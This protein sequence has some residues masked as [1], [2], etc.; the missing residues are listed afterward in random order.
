MC[1]GELGVDSYASWQVESYF[2][3]RSMLLDRI[4]PPI[5]RHIEHTHLNQGQLDAMDLE[6]ARQKQ[7]LQERQE[8]KEREVALYEVW[9]AITNKTVDRLI[10]AVAK[11]VINFRND[12]QRMAN[13]AILTAIESGK[14]G[15]H[16][17]LSQP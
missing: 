8:R 4:I 1:T 5:L 14:Y 15:I 16:Y 7:E 13:E 2:L 6:L 10:F 17:T 9:N 12:M 11:G 3:M